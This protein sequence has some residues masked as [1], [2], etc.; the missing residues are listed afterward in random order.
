M[1][2][3]RRPLIRVLLATGIVLVIV[4]TA[5]ADDGGS[6]TPSPTTAPSWTGLDWT[7][8]DLNPI[9]TP[10][11]TAVQPTPAAAA[12]PTPEP[13]V[14]GQ[15]LAPVTAPTPA[16]SAPTARRAPRAP[17]STSSAPRRAP[18][19]AGPRTTAPRP[20]RAGYVLH[21]VQPGQTLTSIGAHYRVPPLVIA[22]D[23]DVADPDFILAWSTLR[24]RTGR[25]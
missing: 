10:W 16:A 23:N 15:R 20:T 9:K 13:I 24:I 5:A 3:A 6:P 18:R 8:T 7:T 25:P 22:S 21:V 2:T 19:V 11:A 12:S 17:S 1:T 14:E 4:P